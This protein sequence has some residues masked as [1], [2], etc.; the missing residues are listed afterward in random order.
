[1][2]VFSLGPYFKCGTDSKEYIKR[3]VT[4]IVRDL[5]IKSNKLQT[6]EMECL[7]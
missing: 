5:E 7:N 6:K 3:K 4:I 1:M 2:V